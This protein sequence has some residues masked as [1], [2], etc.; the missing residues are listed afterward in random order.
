[1]SVKSAGA[2]GNGPQAA[3]HLGVDLKRLYLQP[4]DPVRHVFRRAWGLGVVVECATSTLPGGTCLVRVRFMDGRVRCFENNL[5]N[6][7]CGYYFG[8][9]H[10]DDVGN[11]HP[12]G[13]GRRRRRNAAPPPLPSA[14]LYA[15][16][17]LDPARQLAAPGEGADAEG[18]DEEP[19]SGG[20]RAK[21]ERIAPDAPGPPPPLVSA[22]RKGGPM[23]VQ[24]RSDGGGTSAGAPAARLT[25]RRRRS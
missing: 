7:S 3:R 24:A 16:A 6:Q 25:P 10:Y 4:G 9:R 11:D 22:W 23:M 14:L 1:M 5:D 21:P 20:G 17:T 12:F 18:L 13:D 2:P 8:L 19:A 15:L